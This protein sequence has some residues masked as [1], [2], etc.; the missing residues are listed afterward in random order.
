MG[1]ARNGT[2][3]KWDAWAPN[4]MGPKWDGPQMAGPQMAGPKWSG[5]KWPGPKWDTPPFTA[6]GHECK[7]KVLV[8]NVI[9]H[10]E[11]THFKMSRSFS[12]YSDKK[13]GS[14]TKNGSQGINNYYA[15]YKIEIDGKSFISAGKIKDKIHHRWVYIIG[16]LKEEFFFCFQAFR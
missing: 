16:S 5:P 15:P 11:E 6:F 2:G 7:A 4:G 9:Q 8:Q 14:L 10:F 13:F 12:S 3:P 1:W